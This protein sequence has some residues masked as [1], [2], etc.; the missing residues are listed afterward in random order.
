MVEPGTP[1]SFVARI[2][3]EGEPGNN[4]TWRGHIQH[5]QGEEESYF[6]NLAEMKEFLERISGVPLLAEDQEETDG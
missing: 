4:P 5:V 3:L 2:W 1:G 6:Q